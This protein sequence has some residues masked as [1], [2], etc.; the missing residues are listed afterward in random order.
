M[1]TKDELN[2]MMEQTMK[3][4]TQRKKAKTF[5]KEEADFSGNNTNKT[6]KTNAAGKTLLTAE[7]REA[8][9]AE[10]K[11]ARAAKK[12]EM[13]MVKDLQAVQAQALVDE[14]KAS[15]KKTHV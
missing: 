15:G 9:K 3:L 6:N 4:R 5:A 11:A 10:R 8:K 1:P 13:A 7:E 14:M 12:E 2:E